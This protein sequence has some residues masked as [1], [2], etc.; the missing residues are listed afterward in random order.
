MTVMQTEAG[1]TGL[2]PQP[3]P[4]QRAVRR[5]LGHHSMTLGVAS[6]VG[7]S[8]KVVILLLGLLLW[9][10][11]LIVSRSVT[12]QLRE[13]EFVAAAKTLGASSAFIM[14]RAHCHMRYVPGSDVDNFPRYLRE[15][16][17]AHR[18]EDVTMVTLD[19]CFTAT[20][21]DPSD[22]WVAWGE[23]SIARTTGKKAAILPN[24]GG[25]LPNACF[26]ETLGLPTL[27]VPHSYPACSQHAPNEHLLQSVTHEALQLMAG[28]LWDLAEQGAAVCRQRALQAAVA[29]VA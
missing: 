22:P 29:T 6:L 16:L 8:V 26:S 25:G 13:E 12:R 14:V 9:D 18:F 7:G 17:D 5:I 28:M 24:F 21:L 11:F 10:R 20:R 1:Q 2:L 23:A 19:H 15:H 27:W 3:G 4:W